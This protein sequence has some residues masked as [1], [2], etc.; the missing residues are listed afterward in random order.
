[1]RLDM[2][3]QLRGLREGLA[4]VRMVAGVRPFARVDMALLSG[5]ARKTLSISDSALY[6]YIYIYHG[7]L[8]TP[9]S[10]QLGSRQI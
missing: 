3:H 5:V 8:G 6:I 9:T 4:A 10:P 7:E 1:M 2:Q